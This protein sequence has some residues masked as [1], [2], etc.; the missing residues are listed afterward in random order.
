MLTLVPKLHEKYQLLRERFS[1]ISR[2]IILVPGCWDYL[3]VFFQ[4]LERRKA[5][6]SN[7]LINIDLICYDSLPPM[8]EGEHKDNAHGT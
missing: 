3:K 6:T 8:E 5:Y 2:C 4:A 7:Q 1:I